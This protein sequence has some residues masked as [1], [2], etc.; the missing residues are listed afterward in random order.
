MRMGRSNAR[1][2]DGVAGYKEVRLIER[3]PHSFFI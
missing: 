3:P 1:E 2:M